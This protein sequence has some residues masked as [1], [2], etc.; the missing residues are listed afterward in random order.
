[1]IGGLTEKLNNA[2]VDFQICCE[3][4]Q[5]LTVYIYIYMYANLF[6]YHP[7]ICICTL[8]FE[9][10]TKYTDNYHEIIRICVGSVFFDFIWY[11]LT[12]HLHPQLYIKCNSYPSILA[13]RRNCPP[14]I[15]MNPYVLPVPRNLLNCKNCDGMNCS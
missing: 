2:P 15:Y 7:N 5:C 12:T 4:F 1:M 14:Q 10:V 9:T 8:T 6:R 11:P 3:K 13:V